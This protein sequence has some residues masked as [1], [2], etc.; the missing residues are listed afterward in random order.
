MTTQPSRCP[1]CAGL[2]VA[3][4]EQEVEG[5]RCVNCGARGVG[6]ECW[7]TIVGFY[8]RSENQ[9]NR[10]GVRQQ[11]KR[12]KGGNHHEDEPSQR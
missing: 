2:L 6:W 5:W 9:L 1:R 12:R 8:R 10:F 3:M 11:H 7:S 4:Q